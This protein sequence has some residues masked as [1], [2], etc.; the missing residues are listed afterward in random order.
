MEKK[1]KAKLITTLSLT[2]IV[3]AI[4]TTSAA[5]MK[6]TIDGDLSDWGVNLTGDWSVNETWLPCPGHNS[7]EFKVEDNRDPRYPLSGG[8]GTGVHIQGAGCS[9]SHYDED[10]IW[11]TH[12]GRWMVEPIGGEPYDLEAKYLDEDGDYIYI[13]IVT[14]LDPDET[15]SDKMPG[16]LALNLDANGVTG[17]FGYEYGVKLGT[18]SAIA[19]W[20]I[21]YLPNFTVPFYCEENKP[22]IF[23]DY[24]MGGH[25]NGTVSGAYVQNTSCNLNTGLDNGYPNY[26]IEMAIPKAKVGMAGKNLADPPSPKMIRIGN[27][28]GNDHIDNPI[29]EFLTIAIPV[30]AILGLI[31]VHR[32]KRQGKGREE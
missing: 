20:D 2:V 30:G 1:R 17:S 8:G 18:T 14:S 15:A 19:Q 7:V 25:N 31:Y 16:D 3:L 4:M 28:C 13:A 24:L 27:N 23:D 32:R 21:G 26:V 9:Y 11:C 5:A 12:Y 29:P 22:A 6:Y 10:M